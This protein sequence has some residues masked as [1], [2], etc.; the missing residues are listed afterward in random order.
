VGDEMQAVLTHAPTTLALA[1]HLQR[2]QH[3]SVGIGVGAVTTLAEDSRSSDGPAFFYAR[4]A[5]A[6]ARTRAVPVPLAVAA[7][8]RD[9]AQE[10]ESLL[11]L[12]AAVLRRRTPAGWEMIDARRRHA[13]AR[14]AAEQL[15]ITPQAASQR[16]DA[17]LWEEV[18]GV[19][20]LAARL[21]AELDGSE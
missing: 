16:L 19:E 20:P 14:E 13:T 21:L 11:Q 6:R 9:S 17:A 7:A 3:W 12:M 10:A 4:E 8:D 2:M 15:G 18:A 1:M 5:V